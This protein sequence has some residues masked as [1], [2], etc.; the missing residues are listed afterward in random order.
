[1]GGSA[2]AGVISFRARGD[3]KM[4]GMLRKLLWSG[5]YAGLGAAATIG[6]RRAASKIWRVA[7]GEAPPTKK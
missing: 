6:A 7:T 2:A 5:L 1:V 3:G 4:L